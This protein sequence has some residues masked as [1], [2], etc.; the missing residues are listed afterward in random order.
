[1]PA[2]TIYR[3][4]TTYYRQ[5]LGACRT[6]L[7]LLGYGVG[8][9]R[10][11]GAAEFLGRME[12]AG[13]TGLEQID[14]GDI[15]AHVA[16]LYARPSRLGGGALS[17]YTVRGYV[18]SLRLLF[19]Y[20][21]RHGL[22]PGGSPLAGLRLARPATTQRYCCSAA[23]ITALYRACGDDGRLTALLHLLYGCGL[24]RME[25]V[26]L[27]VGDVDYR[28]GLLY[29]RRG[30]GRK[31]R[32]VPLPGEGVGAALREYERGQRWRWVAAA[33]AAPTPLPAFL[34]NGRGTRM[35]G[36]TVRRYLAR[37]VKRAGLS[38]RITPHVL[39]HSIATHLLLGGMAVERV[40]DFLGH[41]RLETT[42]LY[43][44]I[45]GSGEAAASTEQPDAAAAAAQE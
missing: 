28:A 23:E 21:E 31:R 24:R 18:F 45:D 42:Q 9:T 13:K 30:K 29:V 2:T 25:A 14:A 39:R 43:T 3:L 6:E 36:N 5:L 19:D 26:A 1:M 15:A 8:A 12:G 32:V 38:A 44:H 40:R 7:R 17:D 34:L 4:H 33:A 16:Y 20:A 22:I 10:L 41:D 27:N 35:R 11:G 37:L